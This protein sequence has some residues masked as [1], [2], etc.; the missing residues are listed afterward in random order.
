MSGTKP[1]LDSLLDRGTTPAAIIIAAG[2]IGLLGQPLLDTQTET[3]TGTITSEFGDMN[4]SI[5]RFVR[6]QD[7]SVSELTRT[8]RELTRV[9]NV[10]SL[11][12]V[13]LNAR[14]ADIETDDMPSLDRRILTLEERRS[15]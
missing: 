11:Q 1:K 6:S 9:V 7:A 4:E 8:V 10:I 5:D 14:V 15:R 12:L 2:I 3:I 13:D